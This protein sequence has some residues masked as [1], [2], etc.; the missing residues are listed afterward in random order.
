VKQSS[1]Q[2]ERSRG[3][4]VWVLVVGAISLLCCLS[5]GAALYLVG[6]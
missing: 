3:G 6:A 5:T 2:E 4:L 1:E